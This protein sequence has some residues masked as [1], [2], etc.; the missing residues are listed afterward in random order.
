MTWRAGPPHRGGG[1]AVGP[2]QRSTT[3][4]TA[5]AGGCCRLRVVH[6]DRTIVSSC[7]FE[8]HN[9][10]HPFAPARPSRH[11][12]PHRPALRRR[13]IAVLPSKRCL[14]CVTM[15]ANS[16]NRPDSAG[17]D[18]HLDGMGRGLGERGHPIAMGR[19]GG[20][21]A[22]RGAREEETGGRG[23]TQGGGC[24]AHLATGVNAGHEQVNATQQ[25]RPHMMHNTSW[26]SFPPAEAT[27]P[28]QAGLLAYF[29]LPASRA[30]TKARPNARPTATFLSS[31]V[32]PAAVAPSPWLTLLATPGSASAWLPCPPPQAAL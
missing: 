25:C 7:R 29:G 3:L 13:M 1:G 16:A 22:A 4:R 24:R 23:G 26:Y 14:S 15:R 32:P 20:V 6:P 8:L 19:E 11:W 18:A 27:R 2:C 28:Q 10:T 21:S 31:T 17:S 30:L 5:A 9:L 12:P